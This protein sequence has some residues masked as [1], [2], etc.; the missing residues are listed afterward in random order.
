[1]V[2]FRQREVPE[3]ILIS[4]IGGPHAP[5]ALEL[6]RS[7]AGCFERHHHRPATITLFTVVSPEEGEAGLARGRT[8]LENLARA[9]NLAAEI[10]V[11]AHADVY[12][13]I[14]DE[15]MQH[16]L[17]MVNAPREGL[18]EQRLFGSIPERLAHECPK[19][20]I[21]VKRH[22]PVRSWLSRWLTRNGTSPAH[23]S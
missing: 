14:M 8:M 19:T 10:K 23:P 3:R 22:Q 15:A 4:T 18:L 7:Q 1:V 16:N 9:Q 5:L 21:M 6:A 17:V 2:R 13:A 20:V 12:Q 11:T